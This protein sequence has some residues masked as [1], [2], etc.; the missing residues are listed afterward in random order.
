MASSAIYAQAPK[1]DPDVLIFSNGD[2]LVGHLVSAA[3]DSVTFKSDMIGEIKVD[4][5]KIKELHTSEKFAVIPKGVK[6]VHKNEA[7]VPQGT[8]TMADQKIEVG[9]TPPQTLPVANVS[10]VV[11]AA[12]FQKAVTDER[13]FFHD[14]TGTVTA[15]ASL[16]EAT[17]DSETFTG[18]ISLVRAV[19]TENWLN[20][21]SRTIFDFNESYG[22]VSQPGSPTL[23]TS[24]Y[25]ADAERDE[26]FSPRVYAFGQANFDHNFSQGLDL[27]QRYGGG[28]GWTAI[29]DANQTLDLKGSMSYIDQQFAKSTQSLVGSTFAEAYLRKLMHGIVFNQKLS[30]TPTWNNTNAYSAIASAGLALPT[31]KRLGVSLNATDA[32]LNDP[33][34][35]FKKNSFQLTLGLTYALK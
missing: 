29:K 15:G 35:G 4:W 21:R 9:A 13:N 27:Q 25:H 14:W 20:A 8:I 24:I 31:Y 6:I 1:P 23:K 30:V 32:F 33:P 17:Q 18:G 34:P 10:N 3:G 5:K 19:P 12:A 28:I 11:T 16:V 22:T 7:P 26:Y 2:K